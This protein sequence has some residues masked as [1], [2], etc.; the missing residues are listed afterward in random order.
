MRSRQDE[1]PVCFC[2]LT[3][4][5][6]GRGV[7]AENSLACPEGHLVCTKCT[8]RLIEPCND[9]ATGLCFRCPMCRQRSGLT[10]YHMMVLVKGGWKRAREV[11]ADDEHA[12]DWA[13]RRVTVERVS[14]TNVA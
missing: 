1:C 8:R 2:E 6:N 12:V 10:P 5:V 7:I 14:V 9:K 13:K 11:F 4:D 3:G